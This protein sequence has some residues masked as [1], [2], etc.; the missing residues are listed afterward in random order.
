MLIDP[1]L[2]N[3]IY[4]VIGSGTDDNNQQLCFCAY[5]LI[6]NS[7][8]CTLGVPARNTVAHSASPSAVSVPVTT[9]IG[10]MGR[11]TGA[12]LNTRSFPRTTGFPLTAAA[13]ISR[14]HTLC[15]PS[16]KDI[17]PVLRRLGRNDYG[18]AAE[19]VRQTSIHW[20]IS[21]LWLLLWPLFCLALTPTAQP[22]SSGD[23]PD[24]LY[25]YLISGSAR[26][27]AWPLAPFMHPGARSTP[28]S[29]SDDVLVCRF[30]SSLI[31]NTIYFGLLC[32]K[33]LQNAGKLY[34]L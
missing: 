6:Y 29:C 11:R 23:L 26:C 27:R 5:Q 9:R 7:K 12:A 30:C 20:P 8:P 10:I 14:E 15:V 16:A 32:N 34:R 18:C 4:L 1:M 25:P 17:I 19:L 24:L 31:D 13:S 28:P 22:N 21:L 2:G 33:E 3:V